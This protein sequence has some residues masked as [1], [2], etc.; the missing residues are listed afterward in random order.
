MRLQPALCA[1]E[2]LGVS[3]TAESL[4]AL[5]ATLLRAPL[6][7]AQPS[8][9][10]QFAFP[11]PEEKGFLQGVLRALGSTCVD[12]M[13]EDVVCRFMLTAKRPELPTKSQPL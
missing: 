10:M 1:V 12:T 11:F 7:Q 4:V 6:L 3:I 9:V 5:E 2:N 8:L 13:E